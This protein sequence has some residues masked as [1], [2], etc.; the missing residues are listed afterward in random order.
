MSPLVSCAKVNGQ[1][2]CEV[3]DKDTIDA[4]VERTKKGG[5]E[6]SSL[7]GTS[8]FYAPG[9]AIAKM[10]DSIINDKKEVMPCC[11]HVD[12]QYGLENVCV[13]LPCR[14]GRDGVEVVEVPL[15]EQETNFLK[16]SVK[17]RNKN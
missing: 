3:L 1:D 7:M 9:S 12:G 10:V 14:L 5:A 15:S 6:I 16:E 17:K 11:V 13:G 8:A 2:V 4:L